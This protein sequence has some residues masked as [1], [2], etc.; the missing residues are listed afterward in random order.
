MII[1]NL[2]NANTHNTEYEFILIVL[3]QYLYKVVLF[4]K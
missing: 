2:L 4:S 1:S 3:M